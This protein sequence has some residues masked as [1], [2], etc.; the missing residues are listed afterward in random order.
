MVYTCDDGKQ[1]TIAGLAELLARVLENPPSAQVIRCRLSRHGWQHPNIF[2][3]RT[4]HGYTINGKN[5]R[6]AQSPAQF[7]V[8]K[9]TTPG[10]AAQEWQTMGVKPRSG[11]LAQFRIGSWERQQLQEASNG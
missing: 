10:G 4:K 1:Y 8:D 6:K 3:P 2:A 7:N 9:R 11:R 5:A